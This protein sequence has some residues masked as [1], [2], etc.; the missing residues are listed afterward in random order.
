LDG[1]SPDFEG[2]RAANSSSASDVAEYGIVVSAL[3][4]DALEEPTELSLFISFRPVEL[5]RK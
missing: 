2:E 5:P 4:Q 1:I 3:G